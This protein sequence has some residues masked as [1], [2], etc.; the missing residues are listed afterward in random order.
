MEMWQMA[1]DQTLFFVPF[2]SWL[3]DTFPIIEYNSAIV[4][5]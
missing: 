1:A 5:I 2:Y 3:W 4:A